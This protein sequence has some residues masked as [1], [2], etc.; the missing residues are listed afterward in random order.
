MAGKFRGNAAIIGPLLL[1]KSEGG[2]FGKFLPFGVKIFVVLQLFWMPDQV[3]GKK[4]QNSIFRPKF[5][6]LYC[7]PLPKYKDIFKLLRNGQDS[8]VMD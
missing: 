3:L 2:Q 5:D 6:L 8:Y 7:P 4:S 1:R